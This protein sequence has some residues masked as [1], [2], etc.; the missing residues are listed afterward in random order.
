MKYAD[1]LPNR[2]SDYVFSWD[3]M[4]SFQG[5]T[6]PYLQYSYVRIRSIFRKAGEANGGGQLTGAK[7]ARDPGEKGAE[8]HALLGTTSRKRLRKNCSSLAKS[9]RKCWTI[10]GPNLLANYLYELATTFHRFFEECP[11]LRA[12]PALR[13][14]R[15]Q[16]CALTERILRHGLQLLGIEVPARM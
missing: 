8:M 15:L 3:K 16:L 7:C 4:L 2:Q 1:L 5:N 9:F 12:D 6:A 13:A 14:A 11:V 10:I